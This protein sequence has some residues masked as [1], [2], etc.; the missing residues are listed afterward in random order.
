[1]GRV[2]FCVEVQFMGER[3]SKYHNINV[4]SLSSIHFH[5]SMPGIVQVIPLEY[6]TA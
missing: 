1:V 3:I 4:W 2:L 6:E 5:V